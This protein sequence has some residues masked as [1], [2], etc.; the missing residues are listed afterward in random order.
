MPWW[1]KYTHYF[2]NVRSCH[3][4]NK[5][6]SILRRKYG[7]PLILQFEYGVDDGYFGGCRVGAD[8]SRPVV[9]DDAG[10][11]H[12]TSSIDRAGAYWNL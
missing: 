10:T 6:T 12:I 1:L 2:N 9:Y 3:L 4:I 11:D 8:E 5:S 7:F